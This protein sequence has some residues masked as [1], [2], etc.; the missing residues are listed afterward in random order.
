MVLHCSQGWR[1]LDQGGMPGQHKGTETR[2]RVA[3]LIFTHFGVKLKPNTLGELL[4]SVEI[5]KCL[6]AC[7]RFQERIRLAL[8][9]SLFVFFCVEFANCQAEGNSA[10]SILSCWPASHALCR[11]LSSWPP[12]VLNLHSTSCKRHAKHKLAFC[13]S[14]LPFCSQVTMLAFHHF[15]SSVDCRYPASEVQSQCSL[16]AAVGCWLLACL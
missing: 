13:R 11:S 3:M 5:R 2:R 7:L 10:L 1:R 12:F 6:G 9:P 15:T 4:Q 16:A 14:R 8:V